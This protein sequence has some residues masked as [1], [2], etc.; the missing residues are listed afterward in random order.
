MAYDSATSKEVGAPDREETEVTPEM[1]AAGVSELIR[2][3]PDYD[4]EEAAVERIFQAM[5]VLRPASPS[6]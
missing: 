3:H 6:R 4:R 2:F 5:W 1:I